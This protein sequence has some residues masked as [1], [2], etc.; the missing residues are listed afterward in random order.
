[1]SDKKPTDRTSIALKLCV[2]FIVLFVVVVIIPRVAVDLLVTRKLSPEQQEQMR[3]FLDDPVEIPQDWAEAEPFPEEVVKKVEALREAIAISREEMVWV[4]SR[5]VSL[6]NKLE[7]GEE[8]SGEEWTSVTLIL[9]ESEGWVGQ[10]EEL[11]DLPGYEIGALMTRE[12]YFDV[13]HQIVP[14][15]SHMFLL[16]AYRMAKEGRTQEALQG[17]QTGLKLLRRHPASAFITHLTCYNQQ[18]KWAVFLARLAQECNEPAALRRTLV[19]MNELAPV[20]NPRIGDRMLLV[21]AVGSLRSFKRAGFPIELATRG[22]TG[23]YYFTE[24]LYVMSDYPR[25]KLNQMDPNDPKRMEWEDKFGVDPDKSEK[26]VLMVIRLPL[27]APMHKVLYSIAPRYEEMVEKERYARTE[28]DLC[29]AGLANRIEQLQ[30]GSLVGD[31]RG[32]A[33]KYQI[34]SEDPYSGSDFAWSRKQ[35]SFYSVG[36]DR[37]DDHLAVKHEPMGGRREAGD[38]VLP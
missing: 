24:W 34:A 10:C 6:I 18:D 22:K 7:H 15:V 5:Q 16:Q 25:W 2:A 13:E 26:W 31:I 3:K 4:A 36:P 17:A 23:I 19:M 30:G 35:G 20:L 9:K 11:A 8:L 38:I 14:Y 1:M 29:R 12:V 27:F 21:D 28:Y 32:L 33:A 37:T